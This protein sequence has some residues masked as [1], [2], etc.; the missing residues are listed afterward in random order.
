MKTKKIK[1]KKAMLL[2]EETLKIIIAVIGI[3][4]LV[5][6]LVSLYYST[7]N[8]KKQSEAVATVD[9]ISEVIENLGTEGGLIYGLQ[10]FKWYLFSFVGDDKKPNSCTGENCLC[11]CGK[12]VNAFNRQIKEC[13]KNGA[14][15]VVSNLSKFEE[16]KIEKG[17]LT[18]IN[19]KEVNTQI[20]ISQIT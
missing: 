20:E 10:P 9:R 2:A 11:I 3:S 1:N 18:S 12:T 17:G 7:T 16:I 19:I 6:F 5:Y 13:D 15:L 4:L 14:C 8:E